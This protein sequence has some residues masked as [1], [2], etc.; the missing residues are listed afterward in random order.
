MSLWNP[1]GSS[2]DLPPDLTGSSYL[3]C[4]I[5]EMLDILEKNPGIA[6]PWG[7]EIVEICGG[8]GVT[9]YLVIKRKLR[10]GQNFELIAGGDLSKTENHRKVCE[11]VQL[12]KPLVIVMAPVCTPYSPLARLNRIINQPAWQLSFQTAEPIAKLCGR[13]AQIQLEAHRHFLV[14]QPLGSTMFETHPWPKVV[15]DSRSLSIVFDQCQV[16]QTINGLPARKPTELIASASELLKPFC[17]KVCDGSHEH[18]ILTGAAAKKAQK[19]PFEMCSRIAHCIEQLVKAEELKGMTQSHEFVRT[20]DSYPTVA[21]EASEAEHAQTPSHATQAPPTSAASSLDTEAWKKC[22]GCRWRLEK[23]DARHS[24]VIV[25]CKHASVKNPS[26]ST[27][28]HASV[29]FPDFMNRT[30]SMK[31]AAMP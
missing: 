27:A 26:N 7:V 30:R 15:Q 5:D 18:I 13:L 3:A 17:G 19:W 28:Q 12:V 9:S 29:A 8:K 11:Y 6:W 24:R 25:E 20:Q 21:V 2:D 4:D 22:K 16:G 14:E 1:S 23:H 31:T 10:S